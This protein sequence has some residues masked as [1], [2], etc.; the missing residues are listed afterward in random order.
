[1]VVS[2]VRAKIKEIVY[3]K[4]ALPQVMG[5]RLNEFLSRTEKIVEK[6]IH[7]FG[8]EL[9]AHAKEFMSMTKPS[10]RK[11]IYVD[12]NLGHGAKL[13]S[14]TASDAGQIPARVSETLIN[15]IDFKIKY[16]KTSDIPGIE[17]G[18]WADTPGGE[19]P[20]FKYVPPEKS[21]SGIGELWTS[22]GKGKQTPV[23][24]YAKYLE[25]GTKKMKP[26]PFIDEA[27]EYA[28]NKARK[29][30]GRKIVQ[31]M[32]KT[33]RRKKIPVYIRIYTSKTQKG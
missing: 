8:R 11:Y 23:S 3:N 14:W 21:N 29:D 30:F 12:P 28:I 24:K 25:E 18:V 7:D 13:F 1:M 2:E 33:M 10:G 4:G 17:I 22:E 27:M 20:T 6:N 15:S 32:T 5:N 16:S 19:Y 26:R 31:G 9:V